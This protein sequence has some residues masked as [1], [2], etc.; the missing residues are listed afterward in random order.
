M[1][2]TF[3]STKGL[4]VYCTLQDCL[5]EMNIWDSFNE[6]YQHNTMTKE[7][8]INKEIGKLRKKRRSSDKRMKIDIFFQISWISEVC[9]LC[10]KVGS[11]LPIFCLFS[12]SGSINIL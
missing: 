7:P 6:G 3:K 8:Y 9:L 5:N 11:S 2:T 4:L 1:P 12:N 10:L